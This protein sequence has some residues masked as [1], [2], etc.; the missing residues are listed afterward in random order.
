M[1][2]N[3][4]QMRTDALFPEQMFDISNA[5]E[6]LTSSTGNDRFYNSHPNAE[7]V[8]KGVTVSLPYENVVDI[9][10]GSIDD[11]V[12]TDKWNT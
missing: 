9:S 10:T 6:Y 8:A 2:G 4:G 3:T 7:R 11:T 1:Y 5:Q 12:I